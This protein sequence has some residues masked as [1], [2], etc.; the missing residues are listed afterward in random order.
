MENINKPIINDDICPNCKTNHRLFI[1]KE[2]ADSDSRW[3]LY[4]GFMTTSKYKIGSEFVTQFESKHPKLM[5]ALKIEDNN[6]STNWYPSI[7]N[8]PNK[9]MIFP[10][11]TDKSNWK[12]AVAMVKS[13]PVFDRLKYPI[14]GKEGEYYETMLDIENIKHFDQLQFTDACKQLGIIKDKE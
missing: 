7:I 6:L 10:D 11:G 12:W 14:P 9:G 2:T 3:C 4:C 1:E 13:I 5:N 8:I